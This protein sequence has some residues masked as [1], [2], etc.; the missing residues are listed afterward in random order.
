MKLEFGLEELIHMPTLLNS[1]ADEL[2]FT[3]D[4]YRIWLSKNDDTVT[5]ERRISEGWVVVRK[6][7]AM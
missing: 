5:V 6:Y 4:G 1:L 2:K 7:E 3:Q